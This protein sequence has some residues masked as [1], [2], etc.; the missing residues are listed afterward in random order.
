ML[1]TQVATVQ[2]IVIQ[3]FSNWHSRKETIKMELT[4]KNIILM[5]N[6]DFLLVELLRF[7]EIKLQKL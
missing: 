5:Q 1:V 4:C 2:S 7:Y 3:D 6:K